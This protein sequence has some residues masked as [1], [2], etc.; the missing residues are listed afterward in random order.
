[1]TRESGVTTAGGFTDALGDLLEE[2]HRNGV[3]IE[4]G[5]LVQSSAEEVPDWDIE[6]WRVEHADEETSES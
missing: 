2:A 4:G 5:W 6:I 1:M 3:D